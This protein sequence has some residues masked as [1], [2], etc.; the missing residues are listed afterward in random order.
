LRVEHG[1]I[2]PERSRGPFDMKSLGGS[3]ALQ[4]PRLAHRLRLQET[5][6]GAG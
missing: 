3:A 2:E 1:R 5:K 4:R 6:P